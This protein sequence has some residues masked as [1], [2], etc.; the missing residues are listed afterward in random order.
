MNA[1]KKNRTLTPGQVKAENLQVPDVGGH[2][3]VFRRKNYE[4]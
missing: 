4:S 1:D 3:R 2:E